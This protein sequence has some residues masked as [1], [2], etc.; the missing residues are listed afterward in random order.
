MGE[1]GSRN[2]N[3]SSAT[4]VLDDQQS[5]RSH[6]VEKPTSNEAA[7][8][9]IG[10]LSDPSRPGGSLPKTRLRG[11]SGSFLESLRLSKSCLREIRIAQGSSRP[12]AANP[13]RPKVRLITPK[14]P[15]FLP[16][17]RIIRHIKHRL[18]LSMFDHLSRPLSGDHCIGWVT[19]RESLWRIFQ[20]KILTFHHSVYFFQCLPS[21]ILQYKS[22][23]APRVIAH[24]DRN[25]G[26][27]KARWKR[28][29]FWQPRLTRQLE[30]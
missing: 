6:I 14:R 11:E 26:A 15:I 23:T 2:R 13:L 28:D 1:V 3:L 19:R 21:R 20:T 10:K 29:P 25:V 9:G 17:S 12:C 7:A 30:C 4:F 18:H 8:N 24:R 16:N 5:K 22:R 27:C